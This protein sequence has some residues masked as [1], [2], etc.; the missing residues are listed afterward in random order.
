[1]IC[2]TNAE[3]IWHVKIN[4]TISFISISVDYFYF[5]DWVGR[6][7][8]QWLSDRNKS[9]Y[10]VISLFSGGLKINSFQKSRSINL[11]LRIGTKK[12]MRS[13]DT[14]LISSPTII[15]DRRHYLHRW[16]GYVSISLEK[17]KKPNFA[18]YHDWRHLYRSS[19]ANGIVTGT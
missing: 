5:T 10:R 14:L 12:K 9:Q 7:F 19:I 11:F 1:M 2:L 4:R 3:A 17:E 6:Y 18:Y 8:S 16:R 15:E 13:F